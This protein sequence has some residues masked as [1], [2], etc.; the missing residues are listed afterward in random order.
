[1]R[2]PAQIRSQGQ[3]TRLGV[4]AADHRICQIRRTQGRLGGRGCRKQRDAGDVPRPRFRREGR[5]RRARHLQRES[6]ALNRRRRTG[7]AG[8]LEAGQREYSGRGLNKPAFLSKRIQILPTAPLL[9]ATPSSDGLELR[10]RGSWTAANVTT[11]E[12]LSNAVTAQ[13]DRARTVKV[14]MAEVRELDTLGAWLLEKMS[15]RV[16]SAGHRADVVGIADNYTGLIEEV[17]QVNRHNPAP[18]PARN[19]VVVRVD[20][21]GRAAVGATEDVAVFLQMLGSLFLAIFGLLRRPRSLRVTSL[22][23]QLYRVGWLA[24]P[25]VVLITFLIGAIIAQ[26]GIFHFRKFGADSYVV[27]MVGILELQQGRTGCGR[28]GFCGHRRVWGAAVAWRT[29]ACAQ[30]RDLPTGLHQKSVH[31]EGQRQT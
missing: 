2:D 25:I 15:R 26:Q 6:R 5:S 29:G 18:A 9:T 4:D 31:P 12:A 7:P 14:D 1:M 8:C 20:E 28:S 23:Y 19:P 11:L 30:E 3:G 27:D 16:T 24:I 22:V 10:P 17:R 21:I 13:L